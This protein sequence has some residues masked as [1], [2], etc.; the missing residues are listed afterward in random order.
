MLSR[1]NLSKKTKEEDDLSIDFKVDFER[2]K[3]ITASTR[4]NSE[5]QDGAYS[6]G[7]GK[8]AVSFGGG[9]DTI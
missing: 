7:Q 3:F 2:F 1:G 5:K 9:V 8:T 6:K 4:A